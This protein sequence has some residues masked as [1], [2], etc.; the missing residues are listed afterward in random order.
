MKSKSGKW[1]GID[2]GTYNSSAAIRSDEGNIEIIKSTSRKSSGIISLISSL[3][4][5]KEFP[6]FISFNE[7]GKI[8]DIGLNSKEKSFTDPEFVVWGIKRLLGKTYIELKESGEL[9][10][11]P[12]TIKPDRNNGQCLINVGINQYSPVQ[13]CTEIFKKIKADTE[14]QINSIV[15]SAVIS[16]PAYFDPIRITP[17]VEAAKS[18]GFINVRSIPEPVAAAL[19]YDIDITVKPIKTLVFDLGAGTLDVTAGY[20]FR[21]PD[22]PGEFMFQVMKTTGDSKLGGIDMD[23]RLLNFIKEKC[24]IESIS[25]TDQCLIRRIAEMSKI[26]LSE[27]FNIEQEFTVNEST[28][29]FSVNQY[30]LK[31]LLEGSGTEKNLLEECRRQIMAAI[32]EINW[33]TQEIQQ[34]ILIGG[35]TRLLCIHDMLKVVF[36]GNPLILQQLEDFYSGKEKIDR[37]TAVSIG[38]ALS[39]NRITNDIVP[40]GHGIEDLE[41]TDK[42]VNYKPNI[43][44]PRDSPYP[45][46]SKP[47]LIQWMNMNGLYEFKIIQHIPKSEIDHFG[48]E[49]RFIGTLKFAVRD[50]YMSMVMVQMGYNTNKELV[51]FIQNALLPSE[52]AAYV[53]INNYMSIGMQYP[54]SVI[55]PED[56]FNNSFKKMQPSKETLEKFISWGQV[57]A[58]LFQ[59]KLDDFPISQ[60]L[61]QQML[62]E[63]I[64]ILKNPDLKTEYELLYTKINNLIWNSCSKGLLTQNE[65]NELNSR[66]R[67]F[68]SELFKLCKDL[69]I[70]IFEN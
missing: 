65:F 26:R 32:N 42:L 17:I 22:Q 47:F 8:D 19:A 55:R 18:A 63:I 52:C 66:L 6:S 2:L 23:D 56:F 35:P 14:S 49:Y 48:F 4:R 31:S 28:Y 59:K 5:D 9:D 12:F 69:D 27:E 15:D 33:N 7:E 38:A 39:V 20:L 41:I 16:V 43:M 3:E 25:R 10:R 1:I 53:G 68:E 11:F 62:D 60:M 24:K 34:L 51:V 21:H 58:G 40:H 44:V 70:K 61:I 50:P 57:I 64:L 13:L 36:Y 54:L 30:E 46:K 67:E 37:M 29:K 45:F